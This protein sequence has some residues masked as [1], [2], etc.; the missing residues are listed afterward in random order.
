MV[1]PEPGDDGPV[2][3][4]QTGE[5]WTEK[6]GAHHRLSENVSATEPAKLQAI[7]VVD[8]NDKELTTFE[9]P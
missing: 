7:F 6:L 4:L 9:R 2:Q 5:S 3:V 1:I 8:T